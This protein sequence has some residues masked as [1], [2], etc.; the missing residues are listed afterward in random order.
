MTRKDFQTRAEDCLIGAMGCYSMA[1]VAAANGYLDYIQQWRDEVERILLIDLNFFL[2]SAAT[3]PELDRR[4]AI[5]DLIAEY[6]SPKAFRT[7]LLI[8][9]RTLAARYLKRPYAEQTLPSVES[10]TTAFWLMVAEAVNL[11]LERL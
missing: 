3:N 1:E 7:S 2:S 8:A 6:Y 4:R 5:D 9:K 10:S 11:A